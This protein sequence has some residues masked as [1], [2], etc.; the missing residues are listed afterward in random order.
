MSVTKNP[1]IEL[2]DPGSLCY[3]IYNELYNQ[4]FNAQTKKDADNPFGIEEGDEV[5]LRLHNTAYGFAY[6]I[7]GSVAGTGEGGNEGGVLID[8]LKKSGGDM[9]G[10]LRANY[11][12]EAG[13]NN[14][15]I[16]ET[17]V[18]SED[19]TNVYGVRVHGVLAVDTK[20]LF[21]GGRQVLSFDQSTQT[22]TLYAPNISMGDASLHL[23]G[24]VVVGASKAAGVYLSPDAMLFH[25]NPVY[26]AAN[27]NLGTVD[28]SMRDA[29]IKGVLAVDG[30]ACFLGKISA[31]HGVE[32][33]TGGNIQVSLS[34]DS[35]DANCHLSFGSGFGVKIDGV[36]VLGRVNEKDILLGGVRGDLLLGGENTNKIRL[37]SN[38]MDANGDYVLL[39]PHGA[40]CF[41]D[42]LTVRHS[43]GNELLSSYRVDS[44]DEGI[45]I[46]KRLR[47]GTSSGPF[48]SVSQRGV[49]FNSSVEYFDA[50]EGLLSTVY[51]NTEVR[52]EVSTSLYR[53]DGRMSGS[54][55]FDTNADSIRLNKPVEAKNYIGIDNSLTRLTN[56]S[57]FL[58]EGSYLLSVIGGIKH[59][60]NASFMDSLSSEYFSSGFSGAGWAIVHNRITGNMSATFDE[61]TVR[62]RMRIYELEVQKI[63]AT[64]GS[65]WVSD[66][67]QGDTVERVS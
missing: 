65:L 15:R 48:L 51:Y 50:Q 22:A 35:I 47:F 63:S 44:S 26:H 31:L 62:K 18:Y 59:F 37:L 7:A 58:S 29:R 6:A 46:H 41:P 10:Q 42:S 66:H 60:G 33:G 23:T 19:E 24:E 49:L 17:F 36:M 21:I 57:L 13:L 16:V 12:F 2:L 45:V 53:P 4:F 28:W 25:N 14:T 52:Y 39:T 3:S 38:L 9:Q 34:P 11:G 55:V 1:A 61:L 20:G 8:Y 54:L 64:N 56:G 27:A 32:L 67:C 40:A 5:S 43:F 30:I